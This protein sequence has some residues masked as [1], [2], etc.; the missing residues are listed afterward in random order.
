MSP[1][2]KRALSARV[3]P[4]RVLRRVCEARDEPGSLKPTCPSVPIPR[5]Y[6]S[7]PPAPLIAS[8]RCWWAGPGLLAVRRW[9]DDLACTQDLDDAQVRVGDHDI[10]PAADLEGADPPFREE[11]HT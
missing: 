10:G 1:A 9:L 6:R 7:T 5:V 3:W 2:K 8:T 4:M 11:E